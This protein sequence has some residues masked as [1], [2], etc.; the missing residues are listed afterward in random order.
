LAEK[1]LQLEATKTQ[2]KEDWSVNMILTNFGA[3]VETTGV[4]LSEV[5]IQAIANPDIQSK[6]HSEIDR[7]RKE[8]RIS[9]PPRSGEM[10]RELPYLQACLDE[11]MRLHNVTGVM[12]PRVVP[13]E[14]VTIE[15]YFI[16]GGVCYHPPYFMQV[17]TDIDNGWN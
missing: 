8:G 12:F 5:I 1:I 9:D 10:Q 14:G 2:W 17:L 3:G 13:P 15:G 7:A 6:I 11:A 4:T 16:P